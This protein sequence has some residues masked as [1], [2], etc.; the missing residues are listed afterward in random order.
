MVD[1][2]ATKAITTDTAVPRVAATTKVAA[3]TSATSPTVTS[4]SSVDIA[5]TSCLARSMAAAAP[6][7]ADRVA[8]I[9]KAIAEGRF[10]L[11]PATIA[12]RMI[13]LKLQWKPYDDQ[14]DEA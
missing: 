10:P 11:V 8:T 3:A 9:K 5:Q 13:A 7:D 2:I 14:H 12:D 1:S 4:G 6:V